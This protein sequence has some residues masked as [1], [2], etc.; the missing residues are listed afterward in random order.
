MTITSTIR[1]GRQKGAQIVVVDRSIVAKI[2]DSLCYYALDG[3]GHKDNIVH[4]AD[5][6]Y[7]SKAAAFEQLRNSAQALTV[8]PTY[9]G[10]W[11]MEVETPVKRSRRKL[12]KHVRP[13]CFILMECIYGDCMSSVDLDD[14]REET[15]SAILKKAIIAETIIWD[16]GVNHR[17]VCPRNV[18]ILGEDYDDPDVPVSAIEV[19]ILGVLNT[20]LV[21]TRISYAQA[22]DAK[23]D[24]FC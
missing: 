3:W 24:L 21:V 7:R 2:Y 6:D 5:R 23:P 9:Y 19:P 13:V 16:A 20:F 17:D 1:T 10:T 8:T 18:V 15:R 14:L 22:L 11:T 12:V 4:N